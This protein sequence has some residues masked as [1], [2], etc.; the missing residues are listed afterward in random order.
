MIACLLCRFE[1]TDMPGPKKGQK[2][3]F[4]G[5]A[6][7]LVPIPAG[8]EFSAR[9]LKGSPYDALLDQLAEK[10]PG[11]VLKFSDLRARASVV[12]RSKKKGMRVSFAER[13]SEL[14]V[15]FDGSSKED[16]DNSR[17]GKIREILK[18]GPLTYLKVCNKLREGGDTLVDAPL[19]E[20]ILLQLFKAGEV[21]RQEGGAFALNPSRRPTLAERPE[22][23]RLAA[24]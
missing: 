2:P 5:V 4:R 19:T 16:A 6:G 20:L 11:H 3:D 1:P 18:A 24:H 17:K 13:G 8:L 23:N 15:R 21:I 10:G 9:K 12:A 22:P 7:E 14:F